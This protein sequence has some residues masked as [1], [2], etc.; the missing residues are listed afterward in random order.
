MAH[1][2]GWLQLEDEPVEITMMGRVYSHTQ[3]Y[4]P[5]FRQSAACLSPQECLLCSR[6]M[7]IQQIAAIP[8]RRNRDESLWLLRLLPSQSNLASS[9]AA[10]GPSLIGAIFT[11]E[12]AGA[13]KA[14]RPMLIALGR[15]PVNAPPVDNYMA[16][17]GRK[18]Y[19]MIVKRLEDQLELPQD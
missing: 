11:V 7:P 4:V 15:E 12:R 5:Q 10:R 9:L 13:G 18:A 3:H 14:S 17:L 16:A 19:M 8:V 6:D 1:I 2:N